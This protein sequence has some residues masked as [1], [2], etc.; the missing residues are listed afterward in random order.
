MPQPLPLAMT[1]CGRESEEDGVGCESLGTPLFATCAH[2]PPAVHANVCP[3]REP[4][5][6]LLVQVSFTGPVRPFLLNR[7]LLLHGVISFSTHVPSID[8]ASF[9]SI[10]DHVFPCSTLI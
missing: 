6:Q 9:P 1:A 3:R 5:L 8:S 10:V 7:K 2:F 4:R